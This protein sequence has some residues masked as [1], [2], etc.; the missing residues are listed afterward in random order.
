MKAR[1]RPITLLGILNLT[2][3]SFYAGSRML[4]AGADALLERVGQ[5]R[6]EAGGLPFVADLGAC[7]TRPGSRGV[8]QDEEWKRLGPA[9]RLLRAHF[10]DLSLSIDTYWPSVVRRAFD[11]VG[12]V[13]VN[14]ISAGGLSRCW[15]REPDAP[16]AMLTLAGQ[17]GLPFIAMHMRGMPETMQERCDYGDGPDAVL[18]DV[19]DYFSTF[20]RLAGE[21]GVQD[22]IVDPGFGFSKTTAQNW[23]LFHRLEALE[24]AGRPVLVGI[25]RK[26]MLYKPLG[27]T[28]EEAL[29]ATCRAHL[30]AL[31]RGA[32]LLR[33]H[34]VGEAARTVAE[35]RAEGNQNPV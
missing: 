12:P 24:A 7:S 1:S 14:D 8:G 26:S 20:G 21:A 28:P 31:R 29:P 30:E 4:G 25:S 6:Q 34:D 17:L 13:M 22:W 5:M 3:D 16:G 19:L 35:Y 32:D 11:A 15:P 23:E 27:I 18:R 9:L 10:P 33:V 2:D